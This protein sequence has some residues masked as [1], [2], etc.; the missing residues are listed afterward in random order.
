MMGGDG[1]M[2]VVVVVVGIGEGG[3]GV[4]KEGLAL[5]TEKLNTFCL[6]FDLLRY[7]FLTFSI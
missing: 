7:N 6:H 4:G 1:W 5:F 2:V 3:G